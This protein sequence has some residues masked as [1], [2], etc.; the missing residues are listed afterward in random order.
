MLFDEIKT[1]AA[2]IRQQSSLV[3]RTGIVMGSGLSHLVDEVK[4]DAVIPYQDIPHFPKSTVAG[5]AGQLI[6]GH[7]SG[8]P[9]V[10][11]AGRFHYYEGY[12]MEKVTLPIRV[13]RE[14]GA[15]SLIL[16]NAAG[17]VN[18][19]YE[20]GDLVFIRDHINLMPANPL[21]GPNDG[22]LGLRFPDMLHAYDALFLTWAEEIA[23]A[24][25]IN[26]HKGVYAAMPGPNF[27]TPA[28]YHFFTYDRC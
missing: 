1:A 10:A 28:E 11:M 15:E 16:S 4:V 22:R 7:L 27:E 3:P 26:V 18:P 19:A 25:Q 12:E 14:L 20:L 17:S 23:V 13:M 8:V 21:R 24:Q 9:I 2:F 6:L 5:H